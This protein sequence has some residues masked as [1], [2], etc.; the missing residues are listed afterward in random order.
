[1]WIKARQSGL[2]DLWH[3]LWVKDSKLEINIQMHKT[4]LKLFLISALILL[5]ASLSAQEKWSLEKCY[6]YAIE[7]NLALQRQDLQTELSKRSYTER[8]AQVLP[9]MSAYSSL[10]YN[11]GR[12]IDP[13]T[14]T[15]TTVKNLSNYYQISSSINVFN[16]LAQLNRIAAAKYMYKAGLAEELK[17]Q[18]L[19]L[20]DITNAYYQVLI[21]GGMAESAA[22][23]VELSKLQLK[24]TKLLQEAG[25][26]SAATVY[27][28][29]SQLS[30]DKLLYTQ[31]RNT[32]TLAVEDLRQLLNL[33]PDKSF[34]V[35]PEESLENLS[36]EQVD[37]QKLYGTAMD[38][39]PRIEA[40]KNREIGMKKQWNVAKGMAMPTIGASATW[41]TDA[42]KLFRDGF[43]P[44][45]FLDQ[46]RANNR[47]SFG[48]YISIP[49]FD[50]L[51]R[52]TQIQSAR[53]NYEDSRL[54]RLQQNEILFKEINSAI[55]NMEAAYDEYV[56][57]DDNVTYS[58]KAFE[59]M[60]KK[61]LTGMA[62]AAELA[63]AKKQLFAA[64]ISKIKAELQFRLQKRTLRFYQ[65]GSWTI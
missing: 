2:Y 48:M 3:A 51:S 65:T 45:P 46:I 18:N 47:K 42:Y 12:S 20:M 16:G 49:I 24:R 63:E 25:R 36:R 10:G 55:L 44:D 54:E 33:S 59:A 60:E 58:Q 15:Y 52:Y 64:T 31:A 17:Q 19:L 5:P 39:L 22:E 1:M 37:A 43:I 9:D 23:Q 40:L 27:Q 14:N 4:I 53:I 50:R 34:E 56:S 26:E 6:Q 41:R 30:S 38:I 35:I 28:I 32:A 57:A 8:I 62:N 7:N 21:T 11:V 29:E 61:F 13:E